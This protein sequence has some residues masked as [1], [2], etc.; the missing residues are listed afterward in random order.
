VETNFKDKIIGQNY[1]EIEEARVTE[2]MQHNFKTSHLEIKRYRL[3][4]THNLFL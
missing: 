2:N 1:K 4:K 3:S